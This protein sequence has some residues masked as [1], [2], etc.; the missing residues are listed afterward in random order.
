MTRS[1]G[2][3]A[4][5][6]YLAALPEARRAA[7]QRVRE[8]VHRVVP[9]AEDRFAYRIPI[10]RVQQDLVGYSAAA[11]HLSLHVMSTTI[12][13]GLLSRGSGLKGAGA[14]LHFTEDAPLPDDLIEEIV[15]ARLAENAAWRMERGK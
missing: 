12:V 10:I 11:R 8:I 2:E 15:A 5:D 7:L 9:G 1:D 6:A 13:A 3:Q 4:V 14:T